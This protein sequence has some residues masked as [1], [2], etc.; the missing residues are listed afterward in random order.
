MPHSDALIR[1]VV[2]LGSLDTKGPEVEFLRE[3]VQAGAVPNNTAATVDRRRVKATTDPS[4]ENLPSKVMGRVEVMTP[5][6]R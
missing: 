3:R 1:Y 6:P 2:I 4:G 5:A